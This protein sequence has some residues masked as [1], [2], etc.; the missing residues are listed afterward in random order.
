MIQ[1]V[2][3]DT[4][5]ASVQRDLRRLHRT[6]L[7]GSPFPTLSKGWW[8]I[9]YDGDDAV[10]FAGMVPSTQWGDTGYL[11]RSGVLPAYRGKG[12][13]KRLIRVRERKARSLGYNWLIS[14]TRQNPPSA[15][16]LISCGYRTFKPSKPWSYADAIYWRRKVGTT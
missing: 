16:S 3:V 4:S 5:R 7:E 2:A 9:A 11:N 15:N 6:L 14:D 8:W 1:I 10:A 12:L 13:Q